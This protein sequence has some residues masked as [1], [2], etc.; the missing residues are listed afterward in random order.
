MPLTR[1]D[2]IAGCGAV[3]LTGFPALADVA[4]PSRTIKM[5]VPYPAGGTTDLRRSRITRHRCVAIAHRLGLGG[6]G[7]PCLEPGRG[8]C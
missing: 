3:L 8:G 1:R 6:R 5:L 2:A 4:Y 7:R